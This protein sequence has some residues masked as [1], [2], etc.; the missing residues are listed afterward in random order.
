MQ[1]NQFSPQSTSEQRLAP[2]YPATRSQRHLSALQIG[3]LTVLTGTCMMGC[4]E[5]E[6]KDVSGAISAGTSS[7]ALTHNGETRAYITYVPSAYD[8]SEELP[9]G[10]PATNQ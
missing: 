3:F 2:A 7:T 8:G 10:R 1:R 9:N 6:S 5:V 4:F